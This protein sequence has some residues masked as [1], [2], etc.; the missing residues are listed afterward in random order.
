MSA[1]GHH[2]RT[3]VLSLRRGGASSGFFRR[4]SKHDLVGERYGSSRRSYRAELGHE[5]SAQELGRPGP[6]KG[7]DSP[8]PYHCT[9]AL[10]DLRQRRHAQFLG[11][12][13]RVLDLPVPHG[14]CGGL[15]DPREGIGGEDPALA[16]RSH[17]L[18]L[19]ACMLDQRQSQLPRLL[20]LGHDS[21][22][23]FGS[24]QRHVSGG[25]LVPHHLWLL[26]DTILLLAGEHVLHCRRCAKRRAGY[27]H[28]RDHTPGH[29]VID[30]PVHSSVLQGGR[31]CAFQLFQRS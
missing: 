25:R 27:Q 13:A 9:R 3:K 31:A 11:L 22:G 7:G 10:T 12:H 20:G 2:E 26:S 23:D 16:E 30:L 14:L 1:P 8:I 24:G 4:H 15:R 28:R 5:F 18:D 17:S 21:H 19:L 6:G 29:D